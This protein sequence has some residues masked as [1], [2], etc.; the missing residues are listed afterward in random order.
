MNVDLEHYC[1]DWFGFD[2]TLTGQEVYFY[3]MLVAVTMYVAF[4]KL[5]TRTVYNLNKLLHRGEYVVGSD[6][7]ATGGV[8]V[9]REKWNWR[10]AL[11][12]TDDFTRGDKIIYGITVVKAILF[13]GLWIGM[14]VAVYTVG[15]SKAG[16]ITY[17]YYV[18]AMF[19]I[20]TSFI[21]M[22]WL[23]IG[24]IR[25]LIR[26]YRDLNTVQRDLDDDGTVRDHDYTLK[27]G[28]AVG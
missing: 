15:V 21:V 11:G 20:A 27:D 14:T 3:A 28:Q 23:S 19:F 2:F 6:H 24:G 22:V 1:E 12:I 25:D 9:S 10:T 13:F 17:H 7:Q 5:G 4:S 16:W 8:A 18:N 26:L